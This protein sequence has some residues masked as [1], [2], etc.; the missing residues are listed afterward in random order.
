MSSIGNDSLEFVGV[1]SSYQ[2][3]ASFLSPCFLAGGALSAWLVATSTARQALLQQRVRFALV[4]ATTSVL[5][6]VAHTCAGVCVRAMSMQVV[7]VLAHG[8]AAILGLCAFGGSK[9]FPFHLSAIPLVFGTSVVTPFFIMPFWL[10]G[11]FIYGSAGM[12]GGAICGARL[13]RCVVGSVDARLHACVAALRGPSATGLTRLRG[14][15]VPAICCSPMFTLAVVSQVGF[16]FVFE[17]TGVF[18]EIFT[19][20]QHHHGAEA[21]GAQH[22]GSYPDFVSKRSKFSE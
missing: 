12:A 21:G 19:E 22:N 11:V 7:F 10:W 6:A 3:T 9:G 1:D 4:G 17:G 5:W 2:C 20:E 16:R 13:S 15:I 18:T 14:I 8:M